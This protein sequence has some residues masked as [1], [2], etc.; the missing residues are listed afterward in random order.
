MLQLEIKTKTKW[1][2]TQYLSSCHWVSILNAKTSYPGLLR[3]KSKV[4]RA[5]V[6]V[7]LCILSCF[8]FLRSKELRAFKTVKTVEVQ[9]TE[10]MLIEVI[11]EN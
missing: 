11:R 7:E 4:K 5:V 1:L 10:Q 2:Q 3:R 6:V 9:K 8:F